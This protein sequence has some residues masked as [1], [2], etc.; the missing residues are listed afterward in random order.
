M[1]RGALSLF[2]YIFSGFAWFLIGA[3]VYDS[4]A[5]LGYLLALL[6]EKILPA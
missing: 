5:S 4:R 2:F 3:G 1:G 6:I